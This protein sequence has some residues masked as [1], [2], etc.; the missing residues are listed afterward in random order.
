MSYYELTVTAHGDRD[1]SCNL[2]GH[3]EVITFPLHDP[4]TVAKLTPLIRD[5]QQKFVEMWP[6][7]QGKPSANMVPVDTTLVV[8]SGRAP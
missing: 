1:P 7:T 4:P 3:G 6:S 2:F 8:R 5:F